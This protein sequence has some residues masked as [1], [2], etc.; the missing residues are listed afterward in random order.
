MTTPLKNLESTNTVYGKYRLS[1][2]KE[3][4]KILDSLEIEWFIESGTL[5]GAWRNHKLLPN[6][7]DFDIAIILTEENIDKNLKELNEIFNSFLHTKYESRIVNTY[8]HKLEIY[9]PIYGNYV[10]PDPK[11]KGANYHNVSID[12][13]VYCKK[14]QVLYPLYY[15]YKSEVNIPLDYIYPLSTIK[16]EDSTYN[17]PNNS[18]KVLEYIYGYLGKDYVFD[19]ITGKYKKKLESS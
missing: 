12:L 1:L 3:V 18:K 11:Y 7:D 10:L 17:C 14:K 16:L 8:C 2:S 9:Q 6:D 19:H 5:L 15:V 13:Q 4:C